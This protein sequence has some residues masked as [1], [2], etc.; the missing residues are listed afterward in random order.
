MVVSEFALDE[1][2]NFSFVNGGGPLIL[3]LEGEKKL[4][5]ARLEVESVSS[6]V[7]AAV[8]IDT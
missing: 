7:V 3:L 6:A 4:L 1:R 2:V 5:G 8:D